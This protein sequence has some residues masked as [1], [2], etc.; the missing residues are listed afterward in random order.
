MG[1]NGIDSD[2]ILDTII[3][4]RLMRE[5]WVQLSGLGWK[6]HKETT[7]A[8]DIL[9][10]FGVKTFDKVPENEVALHCMQDTQLTYALYELWK[11]KVDWNYFSTECEIIGI[12]F[13]MSKYGLKLDE[14][15]RTRL[16]K[17]LS[18]KV[19]YY[20]DICEGQGFNPGSPDQVGYIIAKRGTILPFKRHV[21]GKKRSLDTSK[22][23]LQYVEDPL[24]AIVLQYRK[25]A[26]LLSV[27][28]P[29]RG[30]DRIYTQ[31]HLDAITSRVSS[32]SISGIPSTNLQ[33][34]SPLETTEYSPRTMIIPDSGTFTDFDYSQ[35][36]LRVLAYMSGDREMIRVFESIDPITGKPLDLHQ[37]TA[38]F[39]NIKRKIAKNVGFCVPLSTQILTADGW[40]SYDGVKDGDLVLG[41]SP[42][43][44]SYMWTKVVT[45]MK[46]TKTDLVT[47]GNNY[48]NFTSTPS[49]RWYGRHR[50]HTRHKK[51]RYISTVKTTE[52]FTQ[53][54]IITLASNMDDS[55]QTY[56]PTLLDIS[57]KEASII[58]WL[59]TDGSLT[60]G[61][62]KI[63]QK[64]PCMVDKI[65]KLLDK[66]PHSEYAPN[67]S[68]LITWRIKTEWGRELFQRA[69]LYANPLDLFVIH[70]T[71]ESR[72]SFLK[73]SLDAEGHF[74]RSPIF[75]QNAGDTLE[76]VKLSAFMSGY[77]PRVLDHSSL[78]YP[79]GRNLKLTKPY[80]T[81]QEFGIIDLYE[82][83][84]WCL[85]T[86]IGNWVA[87]D[88][89]GKIFITGNGM[90]YGAT[91]QTLKET[92]RIQSI[93][94]CQHLID[95]W[96][97][98]YKG[99]AAFIEDCHKFGLSHGYITTLFGRDILLPTEDFN[100]ESIKRKAVNYTIQG[101]AAEIM[102][103]AMIKCKHLP[104]R[105]QVHDEL[106]F[107]S[108]I[109]ND[110]AD[111][112]LDYIAEFRTPVA[113]KTLTRW[114]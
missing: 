30:E 114:E 24:A 26:D 108:N 105:L 40:K 58:A 48:V 107:D 73:S 9:K 106:L 28:T 23:V 101:S 88:K 113:V 41:Y 96:F 16:E 38:D 18:I 103:R 10:H 93:S 51:D 69:G 46:P 49:H 42:D 12:L 36:E 82:D 86:G 66:V 35:I 95:S 63:F 102:K 74:Q 110:L 45:V 68:G 109:P 90:V 21:P 89:D 98:M 2:N 64:K 6:V 25:L 83:Y 54:F 62:F 55:I 15:V 91:A 32:K 71:D 1:Q 111:L 31:F 14:E 44:E 112:G 76:A 72:R 59:Y 84:V 92:A 100:E 79:N 53:D 8:K 52:E 19:Q 39:L 70:L 67:S 47:F 43:V 78:E 80:T 33:N 65:R 37:N 5:P 94:E 99:A 11:D 60:Q 29:L 104:M 13:R 97:K 22:E 3:M 4:A 27:V 87:K 7:P 57:P 85:Q 61:S 50:V 34:L 56:T 75:S 20:K 77:F 81:C 17:E